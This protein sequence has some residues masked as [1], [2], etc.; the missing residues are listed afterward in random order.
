MITKTV[1]ELIEEGAMTLEQFE[2][3][4]A[5]NK[6]NKKRKL[7]RERAIEVKNKVAES[8]ENLLKNPGST[9][10]HRT[11]WLSVGKD[12]YTRDEVLTALRTLRSEGTLQ[13]IKTSNNNFQIYWAYVKQAEAKIFG[14]VDCIEKS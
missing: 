14:T 11:V 7:K 4:V 3:L 9:V 10:K 1:L 6:R 2:E 8:L 13:T 5:K 12:D